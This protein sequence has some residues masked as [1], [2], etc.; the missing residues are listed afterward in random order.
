MFVLMLT[1]PLWSFSQECTRVI[2]SQQLP[3]R[4]RPFI[5]AQTGQHSAGAETQGVRNILFGPLMFSCFIVW[6]SLFCSECQLRHTRMCRALFQRLLTPPVFGRSSLQVTEEYRKRCMEAGMDRF[7]SS[8]PDTQKN[9]FDVIWCVDH[10]LLCAAFLFSEPVN[11]DQL[12]RCLLD[13]YAA[14]HPTSTTV[15]AA[16]AAAASATS[17]PVVAREDAPSPRV[18]GGKPPLAPTTTSHKGSSPQAWE[19]TAH[20]V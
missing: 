12:K 3:H 16:P 18:S 7:T 20:E 13:A 15:T 14:H 1:A 19:S 17:S 10:W 5:I 11:V 2:R 8:E 4:T 6:L 9:S